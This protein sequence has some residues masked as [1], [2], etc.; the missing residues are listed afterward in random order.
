MGQDSQ[1]KRD[2]EVLKVSNAANLHQD[3][4]KR[5]I[6]M[7]DEDEEDDISK[8][9]YA[10]KKEN[11]MNTNNINAYSNANAKNNEK[12]VNFASGQKTLNAP[13]FTRKNKVIDDEDNFSLNSGD[14]SFKF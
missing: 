6:K 2:L 9:L 12:K 5:K 1:L 10:E 3:N 13:Q 4:L 14:S 7:L 11:N 8:L